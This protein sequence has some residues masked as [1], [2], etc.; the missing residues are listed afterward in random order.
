MNPHLIGVSLRTMSLEAGYQHLLSSAVVVYPKKW[1]RNLTLELTTLCL[2]QQRCA[3][4]ARRR[5]TVQLVN[6]FYPTFAKFWV[7]IVSPDV[8]VY[9]VNQTA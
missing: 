9:D 6:I 3:R 2:H 7:V 8:K 1:A 5:V 4:C